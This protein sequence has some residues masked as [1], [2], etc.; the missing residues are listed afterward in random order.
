MEA[1]LAYVTGS[2]DEELLRR[3]M[4]RR[5]GGRGYGTTMVR[6]TTVSPQWRRSSVSFPSTIGK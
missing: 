3:T 4:L 2:V 5:S 1:M 6:G